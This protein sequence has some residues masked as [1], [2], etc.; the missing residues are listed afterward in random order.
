M[1]QFTKLPPGAATNSKEA[2][3]KKQA[4]SFGCN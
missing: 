2:L 3:A 4:K 1:K